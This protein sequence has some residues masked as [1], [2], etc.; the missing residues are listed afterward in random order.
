MISFR[1]VVGV[2]LQNVPRARKQVI[3]HA[4]VDR[5][6]VGG[7][8]HGRVPAG[9][10]AGEERSSGRAIAAFGDQDVDGLAV[11]IDRAVE[12]VPPPGDL[13]VG[14]VDAPLYVSLVPPRDTMV[15]AHVSSL[16]IDQH[17]KRHAEDPDTG[18]SE[19]IE[20][21]TLGSTR[22]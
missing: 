6:P 7:D 3:E 1:D 8:L 5:C 12:A 16:R 19:V 18:R 20:P 21:H 13:D 10:R 9:Q 15:Y 4:R 22:R 14:L 17:R 11:L 2:L